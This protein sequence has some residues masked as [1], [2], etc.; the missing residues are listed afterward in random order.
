[1]AISDLPRP[2]RNPIDAAFFRAVY[3]A[4]QTAERQRRG[5][6]RLPEP[7]AGRLRTPASEQRPQRAR[8]RSR[9]AL[10]A[11]RVRREGDRP[12][13][14]GGC[15]GRRGSRGARPGGV[16]E[17]APMSPAD[18]QGY[19]FS[20][21]GSQRCH[22]GHPGPNRRPVFAFIPSRGT[23]LGSR[24]APGPTS[25][26]YPRPR[27]ILPRSGAVFPAGIRGDYP[28][29]DRG[30][31]RPIVLCSRTLPSRPLITSSPPPDLFS[32]ARATRI[33]S[34]CVWNVSDRL[35]TCQPPPDFG[36][37]VTFGTLITPHTSRDICSIRLATSS[38]S[39]EGRGISRRRRSR[40]RSSPIRRSMS[41]T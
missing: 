19:R 26:R 10:A 8:S 39:R 20:P 28:P 30:S 18:G 2:A 35:V 32:S 7:L 4:T 23:R 15:V 3:E 6:I 40:T 22:R 33:A 12:H 29:D 16:P 21:L 38:N 14:L 36:P 31:D 25:R 11:H 5:E 24:Q 13:G 27:V 34:V 41:S 17:G 1:M 9:D 37:T